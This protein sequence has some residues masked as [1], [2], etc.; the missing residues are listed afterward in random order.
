[1]SEVVSSL[2]SVRPV[3]S[4]QRNDN[5]SYRKYK[6]SFDGC[7]KSYKNLTSLMRHKMTIHLKLNEIYCEYPDCE[8]KTF[9]KQMFDKHIANHNNYSEVSQKTFACRYEKCDEVF[10]DKKSWLMHRDANHRRGCKVGC[11]HSGCNFTTQ[12]KTDLK[13]HLINHSKDTTFVSSVDGSAKI[14]QQELYFKD[15]L[16]VDK[17]KYFK[18]T[19]DECGKTYESSSG[20]SLH[21]KTIHLRDT[22]YSCEW[23]GCEFKSYAKNHF[24]RHQKVHSGPRYSCDYPKCKAK[25]K[26]KDALRA[27]RLKEHGIGQCYECSWPGCNYKAIQKCLVRY[28]E[29][30]HTNEKM[31]ACTWPGCQYRCVNSSNLKPHMMNVHLK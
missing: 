10:T 7:D 9:N 24:N 15:H 16:E 18:C 31:Y 8:Y 4:S 2:K 3:V 25:Y 30:I 13:I 5:K 6:C 17:N 19:F 20:L 22:Q 1:M 12:S 28:H 14:S 26:V 29:R 27:H 23:P 11:T 21:M